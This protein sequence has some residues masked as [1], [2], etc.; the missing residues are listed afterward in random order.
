MSKNHEEQKL[1]SIIKNTKKIEIL[2]KENGATG[3]GIH[4]QV[5]SIENKLDPI[6]IKDLRWIATMRNKSIHEDF[7]I[8]NIESYEKTCKRAITKI[9]NIAKQ[10]AEAEA[11]RIHIIKKKN[12]SQAYILIIMIIISALFYL[13]SG[14][15]KEEIQKKV[16][17]IDTKI[18]KLD[19][20][21]NSNKNQIINKK[22]SLET[23]T[24]K[25]GLLHSIFMD[26]DEVNKLELDIKN[27]KKDISNFKE[28]KEELIKKKKDL[29]EDLN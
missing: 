10:K 16:E 20:T 7:I 8:E 14:D 19:N 9:K 13:Y 5:S 2:L 3:K 23:E 28:E 4:S 29:I 1:A 22:N 15:N 11:A 6:L 17:E 21:I 25:Q 12:N 27:L 18:E 24:E 26:T